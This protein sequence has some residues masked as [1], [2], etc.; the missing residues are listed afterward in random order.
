M[1]DPRF[2]PAGMVRGPDGT[3][4]DASEGTAPTTDSP[5]PGGGF[6]V[7]KSFLGSVS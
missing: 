5:E 2:V 1:T 7:S 3:L 6:D 4:I